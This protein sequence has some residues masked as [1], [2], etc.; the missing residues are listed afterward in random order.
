MAAT[1]PVCKMEVEEKKARGTSEYKGKAYYFCCKTCK[2][3]F[4]ENPDKYQTD[5]K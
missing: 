3:K 2:K 1:C 5:S 4:D